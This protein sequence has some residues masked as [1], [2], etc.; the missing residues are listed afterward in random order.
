MASANAAFVRCC[1]LARQHG[2]GR[3]EAA[4]LPMVPV[5]SYYSLDLPRVDREVTEAVELAMRVGHYRG[6]LVARL[7]AWSGALLAWDL[8]EASAHGR[9]PEAL[10]A[11]VSAQRFAAEILLYRAEGRMLAGDRARAADLA[12]QAMLICREAAIGQLVLQPG[13][14]W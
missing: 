3:I 6:M 11:R 4:N 9:E 2:F 10:T 1:E 5:T 7:A 13:I 12:A 8:A 14:L